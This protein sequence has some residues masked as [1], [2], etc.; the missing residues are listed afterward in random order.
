MRLA[1]IGPGLANKVSRDILHIAGQAQHNRMSGMVWLP[2]IFQSQMPGLTEPH[3][4]DEGWSF[5]GEG[6]RLGCPNH[7]HQLQ[8]QLINWRTNTALML[9]GVAASRVGITNPL[10]TGWDAGW[11]TGKWWFLSSRRHQARKG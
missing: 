1:R 2:E 8:L 10:H 5:H 7:H 9:D 3:R 4:G 6:P 11:G